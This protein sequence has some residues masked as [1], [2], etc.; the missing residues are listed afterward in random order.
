MSDDNVSDATE[1][2]ISYDEIAD[3]LIEI[4]VDDERIRAIWVEADERQRIRRPYA[5]LEAHL[6]ADEP[7]FP[8]L[9]DDLERLL[10]EKLVVEVRAVSDTQRLAKQ[11]DL[12]IGR[13]SHGGETLPVTVIVEQSCYL[14]K[15]PRAWVVTLHDKTAHL[16]HVM[17][18]SAR[19]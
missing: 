2:G 1:S 16:C 7:I 13:K 5:Q 14:A 12:R 17:D 8:G 9:V 15:R 11:F 4:A 3:R 18:F 10:G 6:A 19:K